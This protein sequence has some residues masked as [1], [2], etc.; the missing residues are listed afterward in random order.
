MVSPQTKQA[1]PARACTANSRSEALGMA[2]SWPT[3]SARAAR[4]SVRTPTRAAWRRSTSASSRR[5][6][7]AKGDIR[8]RWSTS[9]LQALPTPAMARWSVSMPL[10]V[11]PPSARMA[12]RRS[13][14]K[15]GSSGSGPRPARGGTFSTS[16]TSQTAARRWVPPSVMDRTR[17]SS[18]ST[19]STATL[20]EAGLGPR[21]SRP[22]SDRCMTRR[23]SPSSS[24]TY[25][26]RR[27]APVTARPTRESIGG[28]KVLR[29]ATET[30]RTAATLA[31]ASRPARFSART[32]SSGSS[33]TLVARGPRSLGPGVGVGRDD[34]GLAGVTGAGD[35]AVGGQR[36]ERLPG[37]LLLGLLLGAALAAAV[38]GAG[39]RHGGREPLGV[40]GPLLLDRVGGHPAQAGG[41]QLLER[42]LVVEGGPQAGRLHHP[43]L[44]QPAHQRGRPRQALVEVDGPE[45]G[46]EGVG[47]DRGL[48]PTAGE[49]L[50]PAQAHGVADAQLAGHLREHVH[51]HRGRPQLGQ[52]ALGQVG[53]GAVDD[54]GDDQ[55][56]HGVAEELEPFV[57]GQAA[58]LVGEGAVRERPDVQLLA[59]EADPEGLL[60][61]LP[62][63]RPQRPD[64]HRSTRSSGRRC[65][66]AWPAGTADRT[67][68]SGPPTSSGTGGAGSWP[69]GSYA[70]GLASLSSS[71]LSCRP[72]RAAHRGSRSSVPPCPQSVALRSAPHTGQSPAQSG[73]CS[74]KAGKASTSASR[75]MVS[76]GRRSSGSTA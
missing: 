33:G 50:A 23:R 58:V 63:S 52:L 70:W 28:S 56:E 20:R 57:G 7:R 16:S 46:L 6:G 62:L 1:A 76:S 74:G 27:P 5:S 47:Q 15:S 65:A 26:A 72:A 54:V 37:R 44:E 75:A 69:V 13:V 2:T 31:P 32:S 68:R 40:V 55:A 59:A 12:A 41:G 35:H 17:P 67:H 61:R 11:W 21:T 42:G 3:C 71:K 9:S 49:L 45:D 34:V 53:E 60:D 22:P 30:T 64:A 4:A 39:H 29:A 18:K 36:L 38:G 8:A 25:L 10:R 51:V 43:V 24:Q 48:V 73:R 19:V 14:V 66:A